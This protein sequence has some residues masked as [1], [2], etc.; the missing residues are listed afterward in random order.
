MPDTLYNLFRPDE[1]KLGAPSPTHPTSVSELEAIIADAVKR[2]LLPG[3]GYTI[4]SLGSNPWDV[5]VGGPNPLEALTSPLQSAQRL[6]NNDPAEQGALPS[7]LKGLVNTVNASGANIAQ[8][9]SPFDAQVPGATDKPLGATISSIPHRVNRIGNAVTLGLPDILAERM[10]EQLPS[11]VNPTFSYNKSRDPKKKDA[12]FGQGSVAALFGTPDFVVGDFL[13]G[14][15]AAMLLGGV[16]E[17][18]SPLSP[19]KGGALLASLTTKL[20]PVVSAWKGPRIVGGVEGVAEPSILPDVLRGKSAIK[21][22]TTADYLASKAPSGSGNLSNFLRVPEALSNLRSIGEIKAGGARL[23]QESADTVTSFNKLSPAAEELVRK[24]KS[25]MP[26]EIAEQFKLAGMFDNPELASIQT[27][28]LQSNILAQVETRMRKSFIEQIRK[29]PNTEPLQWNQVVAQSIREG[30]LPTETLAR[31]STERL[32]PM[33]DVANVAAAVV[34]H[35]ATKGGQLQNIFSQGSR[36]AFENLAVKALEGD[37]EAMAQYRF[38]HRARNYSKGLLTESTGNRLIRR[39]EGFRLASMITSAQNISRNI[40]AQGITALWDTVGSIPTGIAETV[41]GKLSGDARPIKSYFSDTIAHLQ[42]FN[43]RT[44]FLS[45]HAK[46]LRAASESAISSMP[47]GRF[48][49]M[50]SSMFETGLETFNGVVKGKGNLLERIK[51][52]WTEAR[53]S[54]LAPE[55]ILKDYMVTGNRLQEH[56]F[57]RLNWSERFR[58]NIEKLGYKDIAATLP[59]FQKDTL[60]EG[61]RWA[62]ADASDHAHRMTYSSTIEWGPAKWWLDTTH[63]YPILTAVTGIPFPRFLFNQ[64]Q[65][66]V[67]RSPGPFFDVFNPE[68]RDI[69]RQGSQGGLKGL[70]ARAAARSLGKATEGMLLLGM[71]YQLRTS[72]WAG[73]KYYQLKGNTPFIGMGRDDRDRDNMTDVRSDQPFSSILLF[74]DLLKHIVQKRTIDPNTPLNLEPNEWTEALAGI[75][76]FS[77]SFLFNLNAFAQAFKSDDPAQWQKALLTPAGNYL[78]SFFVPFRSGKDIYSGIKSLATGTPSDEQILRDTSTNPLTDPM[79]ASIPGASQSL[80]ARMDPWTGTPATA[81]NPLVRQLRGVT[82]TPLTR[83]QELASGL[84]ISNYEL[85]GNHGSPTANNL[86]SKYMGQLLMTVNPGTKKTVG[87][88]LVT[89]IK[90]F[91]TSDSFNKYFLLDV[92]SE[93][94]KQAVAAAAE[95]NPLLFERRKL[96]SNLPSFLRNNPKVQGVFDN[97]FTRA[98]QELDKQKNSNP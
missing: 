63:K 64:W 86:V 91:N 54:G 98:Q 42:A 7:I 45:T 40:G 94:R 96:D 29:N 89:Q 21:T 85:V 34:E 30:A 14:S 17:N 62:Y 53:N 52:S 28:A 88:S 90:S 36:Q 50:G 56:W 81:E 72:P 73:P 39:I 47:L 71:A 87:D 44:N 76:R 15:E 24:V 55:D 49:L 46:E 18:G 84:G 10:D 22:P 61:L 32:I 58:S 75:R 4:K 20:A 13:G 38:L 68:F 16:D 33:E 80:P 97:I 6:V 83:I 93:L 59:E 35:T 25:S 1:P 67:D 79:Q 78:G 26:P 66:L 41:V 3:L 19:Q 65:F 57:R 60:D 31:I 9:L 82:T 11:D 51:D 48:D 69:L 5:L 43:E 27:Q 8:A 70:E 23:L 74:G 12:T 77:D 37:A 2:K 92:I 95:E